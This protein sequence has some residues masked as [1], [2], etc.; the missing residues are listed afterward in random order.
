M[1][2]RDCRCD[3]KTLTQHVGLKGHDS[4]SIF[5]EEEDRFKFIKS[6]TQACEKYDVD[7]LVY[8]LMD[9]HVH[10][11]LRGEI[12]NFQFVFESVGATYARWFNRKYGLKGGFWEQRYYNLPIQ[13]REQFLR[14]AAYIFNN[15]VQAGLV[16]KPQDY[17]WSNFCEIRDRKC[18][19]QLLEIIDE[20]VNVGYLI[21]Y[22]IS[23]SKRKIADKDAK[24]LELI[25]G[26]RVCDRELINV[27]RDYGGQMA[28]GIAHLK[29]EKW[30]E[31]IAKL[32]NLGANAFQIAR[33]TRISSY[34]VRRTVEEL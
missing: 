14:T 9:N 33:V 10:L 28:D 27:I 26:R 32:W 29:K 25:R 4:M 17:Q 11:I 21:A 24:E 12:E 5:L 3:S 1:T 31:I 23:E 6:I 8:V 34:F 19:K 30:R 7:L 18:E 16:S 13:S 20:L 2:F 22:T 15:P